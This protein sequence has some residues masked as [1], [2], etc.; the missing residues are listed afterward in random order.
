[1]RTTT[2]WR[3]EPRAWDDPEGAR[4]RA[5]QRA[6]LD[7]RFGCDDHEPGPAP[8]SADIEVFLV[9]VDANGT[10]V[11][12]GGL[13][14]LDAG[15]AKVKRMY[16][17]PGFRGSGV[18]PAILAALEATARGRGWGTLRLETGDEARMPDANRFYR[19]EGYRPIPRYGH[20]VD[21]DVSVCYEKRLD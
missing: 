10:A 18:A 12:C 1:M 17:L 14:R 13:R 2:D 9:A 8:S 20:Y 11:G 16:V 15:T 6:E 21:S 4:L 7:A 19:R 3:I 5:A